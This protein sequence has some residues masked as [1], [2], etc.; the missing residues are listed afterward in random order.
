MLEKHCIKKQYIIVCL[1]EEIL[2]PTSYVR[3]IAH[4]QNIGD[5]YVSSVFVIPR[6]YELAYESITKASLI[7]F[8]RNKTYDSLKL[9]K[10]AHENHIHTIYDI[11]DYLWELPNYVPRQNNKIFLDDIIKYSSMIT[12]P[13]VALHDFMKERFNDIEIKILPNAG[14]IL[15]NLDQKEIITGVIANSNF[16]RVPEFKKIFFLSLKKAAEDVNKIL[17]LYYFSNDPPEKYTDEINLKI[18]WIGIRSYS[19]Y[20]QLLSFLKPQYAFIPLRKEKFSN[21]KSVIKYAEFGYLS[22]ICLFSNVEPYSSFVRNGID[23]F[24]ADN[25]FD[26]W[27]NT[28]LSAFLLDQETR[29]LI[30]S[31]IFK[32]TETLFNFNRLNTDF[33]DNINKYSNK[34]S[35]LK[36][37]PYNLMPGEKNFVFTESYDYVVGLW[38]RFKIS[39]GD[40]D[41]NQSANTNAEDMIGPLPFNA[42]EYYNL[43]NQN[44]LL[45]NGILLRN[46]P[47]QRTRVE[48]L[49]VTFRRFKPL[50]LPVYKLFIRLKIIKRA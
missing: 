38:K 2:C 8:A 31:N 50:L 40:V 44:I 49:K 28:A 22:M 7:I 48:A 15:N 16:F 10:Y 33:I 36:S 43:I 1:E 39:D 9:I 26:S 13:S 32:K 45:Q 14:N 4:M 29:N 41:K 20:K 19:S 46:R 37:T 42:L 23:G 30:K 47:L 27:Y 11:D 21:Y 18:I 24:L 6:D 25:D 35:S 5:N 12:T 34:I 3:I 17:V